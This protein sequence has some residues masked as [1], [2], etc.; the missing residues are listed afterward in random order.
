MTEGIPVPVFQKRV[1]MFQFAGTFKYNLEQTEDALSSSYFV[2]VHSACYLPRFVTHSAD[3]SNL[4]S[5]FRVCSSRVP[6]HWNAVFPL[7]STT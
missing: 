5:M 4:Y 6:G 2:D 1:P 7:E 3:C